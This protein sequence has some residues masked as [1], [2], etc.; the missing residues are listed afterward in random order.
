MLCGVNDDRHDEDIRRR[1]VVFD[2]LLGSLVGHGH[3]V[4]D[5]AIQEPNDATIDPHDQ[6]FLWVLVFEILA[7][8][9]ASSPSYAMLSIS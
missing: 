9:A 3:S 6:E 1:R 5:A 4:C 7:S 8:V 2:E